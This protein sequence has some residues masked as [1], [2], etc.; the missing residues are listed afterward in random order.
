MSIGRFRSIGAAPRARSLSVQ[1]DRATFVVFVV[2]GHRFAVPVESVER[3]LRPSASHHSVEYGGRTMPLTD[4]ASSLGLALAPTVRSR[5]IVFNP[6]PQWIAA[7][8]DVVLEVATIDAS[9]VG[10]LAFDGSRTYL[11]VGAR[12]VFS[13]HDASVLVLDV[14]RALRTGTSYGVLEYTDA[15]GGGTV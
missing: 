14:R 7:A 11:P 3:I 2:G 4:L 8:V 15:L 6:G 13:R 10:P 5:I 1:I 9:E 12:G